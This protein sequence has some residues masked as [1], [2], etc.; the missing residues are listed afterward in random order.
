M[1]LVVGLYGWLVERRWLLVRRRVVPIRGWDPALDGL[2]ILHL[3]DLHVGLR[4]GVSERLLQ[5][6]LAV[7]AD[8]TVIT[9][10]FL[11]HPDAA[12][13]CAQ[14]LRPLAQQ[15]QVYAIPGNHEHVAYRSLWPNDFTVSRRVDTPAV[16][17]TLEQSGIHV[18]V[19]SRVDVPFQDTH[20]TL[21]GIDDMFNNAD[22]LPGTL[23]GVE[24]FG[25][26]VLL[27]H[28][29]DVL[30]HAKTRGV[31][32]VLSGHTHGGQVRIPFYGALAT[33]TLTKLERACGIIVRGGATMHIS[34]GLGT[35]GLP[36]RLFTR[37]EM[38]VLEVRAE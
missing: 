30:D 13:R 3:S 6:A 16:L 12:E 23:G 15:R 8:V 34:P 14:V 20:V 5:R 9:G 7:P 10:D 18:L 38:T 32:L 31:L 37:P 26:L 19:N 35:T 33:A 11:G 36:L 24:S 2:C 22:D 1:G 21:A 4:P 28:S 27:S 29:P 25:S 17:R